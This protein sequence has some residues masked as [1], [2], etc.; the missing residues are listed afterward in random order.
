[1]LPALSGYSPGELTSKNTHWNPDIAPLCGVAEHHNSVL[2]FVHSLPWAQSEG[3]AISGVHCVHIC[4]MAYLWPPA[5]NFIL[6]ATNI[7]QLKSLKWKMEQT[8]SRPSSYSSIPYEITV[9][10]KGTCFS[11]AYSE[12]PIAVASRSKAWDCGRLPAGIVGSNPAGDIR[13]LEL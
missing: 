11:K 7:Y 13:G 6:L 5:P 3:G 10:A 1:M 4:F 12:T 8:I 9:C 2:F